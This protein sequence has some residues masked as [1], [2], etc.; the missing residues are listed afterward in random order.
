MGAARRSSAML[1][2]RSVGAVTFACLAVLTACGQQVPGTPVAESQL[3]EDG[4]GPPARITAPPAA[5]DKGQPGPGECLDSKKFAFSDCA[6]PHDI[7]ITQAGQLPQGLPGGYPDEQSML[8]AALPPC[9]AALQDY[10]GSQDSDATRLQAWAFWPNRERWQHGDRWLLCAATE[11]GPDGR[12]VS[13]TGTV[14]GALVGAGFAGFQLCTAGSPSKEPQLRTVGCDQPHLGEA[15]PGVLALG[16]ATDP[17]PSQDQMNAA[18]REH[19]SRALAGYLGAAGRGD[20]FPAWRMPGPQDWAQGYTD[21]TCYAELARP[22]SSRL[23]GIGT[24]QLP[25]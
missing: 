8:R 15:L 7:E 1:L 24:G 21:I 25:G 6:Q 16:K 12:P 11:L 23:Q 9:R 2:A 22:V 5:L 4:G 20:V 10:L 19:C 17:V 3:D 14:R 13:R 18:A